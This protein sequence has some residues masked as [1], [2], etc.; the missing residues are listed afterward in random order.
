MVC[1][2]SVGAIDGTFALEDFGDGVPVAVVVLNAVTLH[3]EADGDVGATRDVTDGVEV[4]PQGDA[5]PV[6]DTFAQTDGSTGR[7]VIVCPYVLPF[8]ARQDDLH[9]SLLRT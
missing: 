7:Q 5:E 4:A 3:P 9:L 2:T 1:E 8:E 6:S